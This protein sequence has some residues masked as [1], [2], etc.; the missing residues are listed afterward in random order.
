MIIRRICWLLE[1]P[2]W[3]HRQESS[4]L[5]FSFTCLSSN[6]RSRP[7]QHTQH[8]NYQAEAFK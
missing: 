1:G 7:F 5:T 4:D 8:R 2:R 3:N 6:I